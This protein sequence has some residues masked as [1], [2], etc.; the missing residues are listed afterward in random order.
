MSN[1]IERDGFKI[2]DIVRFKKTTTCARYL[3]NETFKVA[4]FTEEAIIIW[5]EYHH[6]VDANFIELANGKN[7]NSHV[8]EAF[9]IKP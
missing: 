4:R 5:G 9:S 6:G 7:L 1:T 2:G 8:F 3:K